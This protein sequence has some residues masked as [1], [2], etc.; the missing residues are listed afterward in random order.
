MNLNVETDELIYWET[1]IQYSQLLQ[2]L[3]FIF[4]ITDEAI[5]RTPATDFETFWIILLF[6]EMPNLW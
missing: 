6:P 1:E 4:N 5:D 3:Q 2:S